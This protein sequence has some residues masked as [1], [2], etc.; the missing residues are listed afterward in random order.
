MARPD[1]QRAKWYGAHSQNYSSANRP[2]SNPINKIILHIT[3]GSWSSAINWF[4]DSRAQVSAHYVV[5]SSDGFIGQCVE[6]KDIAWHA[7]NWP[8]N[9]T[10]IGIEHEG[11]GN[12]PKWMTDALYNASAQLSAYLCRK[13]N[14]PIRHAQS[15][16]EQGFLFHRQVTSTHCPGQYFDISRYL[17]R[18]RHYAAYRQRVDNANSNRFR[19]S[20]NWG[21]SS[22]NSQRWGKD[23][24]YVRP[25][26]VQ[27]AARFKF[28]IP[29]RGRYAVFAWWP[30]DRG[31]NNRTRFLIRT[32]DGWKRRVVNQRQN[33]GRWVWLGTFN[34]PA[35]D[36]W[37]I[38]IPRRSS[39]KGYII[40]DA[41]RIVER[42]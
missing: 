20:S 23:Y 15:A 42:P 19:A 24:R 29:R 25:A 34:M 11:F 22:W 7:G 30:T 4:N 35:G 32:T 21:T 40:A 18:V 14:V 38:R 31:Y 12:D 6:E 13:Y 10:S 36:R 39:G 33:G 27:D 41:V 3:E 16:S 9:Q 37:N 5:R 8:V 1:Y 28:R 26:N 2:S 17:R